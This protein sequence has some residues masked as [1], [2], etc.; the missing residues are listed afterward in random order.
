[1]Y[2][3]YLRPMMKTYVCPF[4]FAFNYSHTYES[5]RMENVDLYEYITKLGAKNNLR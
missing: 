5:V 1:M 3:S 4:P 2:F